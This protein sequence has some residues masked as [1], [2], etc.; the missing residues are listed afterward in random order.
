MFLHCSHWL[1]S[2]WNQSIQEVQSPPNK[3]YLLRD[4]WV[5]SKSSW[6]THRLASYLQC[7]YFGPSVALPWFCS[8]SFHRYCHRHTC[9]NTTCNVGP[10]MRLIAIESLENFLWFCL[11]LLLSLD[12]RLQ[13][14]YNS[15]IIAFSG[16]H[17]LAEKKY[18]I[19][20]LL[21]RDV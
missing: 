8:A 19:L 9:R 17:T 18:I 1:P 3:T 13:L 20:K 14:V 10:D 21:L 16:S 7:Q 5:R 6:P 4:P 2:G 11:I 12:F 15:S